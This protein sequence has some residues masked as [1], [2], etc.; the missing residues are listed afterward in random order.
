MRDASFK[1]TS[2]P[3]SDQGISRRDLLHGASLGIAASVGAGLLSTFGYGQRPGTSASPARETSPAALT[4]DSMPTKFSQAEYDRR[5]RRL[6]DLMKE[7]E[8]DCLIVPN[9]ESDTTYLTGSGSGWVVFPQDGKVTQIVDPRNIL[10]SAGKD[11]YNITLLRGGTFQNDAGV[12]LR[13]DG[14]PAESVTGNA[15]GGHWSAAIIDSLREKGMSRA[16][17]GV[18]NMVGVFRNYEGGVSYTTLDRVRKAFPQAQFDSA[19]DVL[20]RAQLVKG[21]EEIEVLEKATAVAELGCQAM[22]ETARPG[23]SLREVWIAMYERMLRASGLPGTIAFSIHGV[24]TSEP[25]T[26]HGSTASGYILRAGDVMIE[27]IT[28]YVMGYGAQ[29]DHPVCVGAPAPKEWTKTAQDSIDMFYS[30]LEF[31]APGKSMKEINDYVLKVM[32]AKGYKE[33]TTKVVFNMGSGPRMGPNRKEG[34]NLVVEE[35][36]YINALKPAAYLPSNGFVIDF[37]DPVVVTD[38]GARRLAKRKLEVLTLGA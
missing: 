38:K 18:A 21:P 26:P 13:P 20:M 34:M 14:R 35:G 33:G 29:V 23:V 25:N 7:S 37:G 15:E 11:P 19:H 4:P 30:V 12:E 28:G 27:E 17:I 16:R 31:I 22:F 3:T 9:G 8:L 2:Q 6:R 10:R 32:T 5:W 1:P 36:W 24:R